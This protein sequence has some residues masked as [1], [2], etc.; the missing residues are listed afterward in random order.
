ME[1]HI[2]RAARDKY[3]FDQSLF[4]LTGNVIFRNFHQVRIFAQRMNEHRNLLLYPENAVQAGQI[5]AM[6]LID[7]ILH[8]I[9]GLYRRQQNPRILDQALTF[10]EKK[11]GKDTVDTVLLRFVERFPP[12]TVYQ[13]NQQVS[14]YLQGTTHDLS[15]R[16]ETL[17]ELIMLW[18]ANQNP[19]FSQFLELFDDAS[20]GRDTA[21]NAFIRT[22]EIFFRDQPGF[23]PEHRSLIRML[24]EPAI[25]VPHSLSGQLE[26]IRKKWG[27]LLGDYLYRLL[28]SLDFLQEE[29]RRTFTG[30]GPSAGIDLSAAGEAPE[31]F[32]PDQDWMPR[33]V[34]MAKNI[35]VW[36]HQLSLQYGR[37]MTH[38]DQIPGEELDILVQRGFTGLWL[39][40]IWERS[41]SSQRIKRLCG[42]PEAEASAYSLMDYQIASDLGGWE[43]FHRLK[44][45]AGRRGIRLAGDMVPNHMGIDSNWVINHPDWFLNLDHSPFPTYTFHGPDLSWHEDVGIYLEDHYYTRSD[46]AV[47]FLRRN[48]RTGETRYIYHGNDGTGMPWN[49]TAQLNFLDPAVREGVIRTILHVARNFPIIRFDAAM[50]LV[51]KHIQ[52]LWYPEPGTGG[53][54]PSRAG[55]GLSREAFEQAMPVEFWREVVDRVAAEAPDTLLLAEAFWMLEGYFVRTLGM[56]RVYNSAFMNML[57]NEENAAYRNLIKKTLSFNP[58]ILKRFVNFMSNP[59]EETAVAQFGKEDKYFG[60]CTLMATLPGLPMFGHGQIEGHKEKYGMEYRR[61]YWD[62]MPDAGMIQRHEREIFPLLKKRALFAHVDRFRLYDFKRGDGSI[63]EN[64]FAYSNIRNGERCLVVYHNAYTSTAGWIH[65]SVPFYDGGSANTSDS[66]TTQ[67]ISRAIDLPDEET[68][69]C[70]FRDHVTDLEYIRNC[71]VL[72]EKGLYISLDAYK[73]QVFLDF[74]YLF[75]DAQG[76]FRRLE[77]ALGGRG[78]PSVEDAAREWILQPVYKTFETLLHSKSVRLAWDGKTTLKISTRKEHTALKQGIE[79]LLQNLI[80][81]IPGTERAESLAEEIT[82]KMELLI[83]DPFFSNAD[84]GPGSLTIQKEWKAARSRLKT[85]HHSHSI[86]TAWTL[87]HSLGRLSGP[88]EWPQRS[89]AWIDEMHLGRW[90]KRIFMDR[91]IQEVRALRSVRLIRILT[92]HSLWWEA[93]R[94][95]QVLARLFQDAEARSFIGVNRYMDRL[96]FHRESF[97]ELL[98]FLRAI[99]LLQILWLR[100]GKPAGRKTGA[101]KIIRFIRE[102]RKAQ[103]V[104]QCR[105]DRILE[106]LT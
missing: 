19:A 78:V 30:P 21:Y 46:A 68:S 60:V 70:I 13:G 26:Y 39:I 11:L 100:Q 53:A 64:V 54:I 4:S 35:H 3:R 1:F 15:H 102:I 10:L 29:E 55:T 106:E 96:W 45:K 8:Y 81:N 80:E 27:Y 76:T 2:S 37:E 71:R 61:A 72:A 93:D 92:G 56:H 99:A 58:E 20:L 88:E 16:E 22:L 95:K 40:G 6:G 24:R 34:L 7:E 32:S 67:I 59:D 83:Q 31:R 57:K 104:S 25:A 63:D 97:L 84:S 105:V 14:G 23:G 49:D 91:G 50:T 52:R 94:S 101:G 28:S 86:L 62:E 87:L 79:N 103:K 75:D 9:S 89:R 38:L 41:V 18:L 98:D 77:T 42:N 85:H 48:H 12:V 73:Y 51:R 90:I 82:G 44:E 43:A 74:R 33:V 5:N 17:E 36:L 66:P 69:Y 65:R 47:V